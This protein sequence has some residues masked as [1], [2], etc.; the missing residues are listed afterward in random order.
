MNYKEIIENVITTLIEAWGIYLCFLL[1]KLYAK[2]NGMNW[3]T[4]IIYP[5]MAAIVVGIM[6]LG[7]KYNSVSI[8]IL[9][10]MAIPSAIGFYNGYKI[11][12]KQDKD[13]N[14]KQKDFEKNYQ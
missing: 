4:L 9:L 11:K 14:S 1:S 10:C 6:L 5:L 2:E 7:L 12:K 13:R 3:I 8:E